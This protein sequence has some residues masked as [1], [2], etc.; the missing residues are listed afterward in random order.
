[1]LVRFRQTMLC[2][3]CAILCR[4]R[5]SACPATKKLRDECFL[6]Y[7]DEAACAKFIEAHNECL[8]KDGFNV[9]AV[10]WALPVKM[11]ARSC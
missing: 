4:P 2:V 3:S 9:R 6:K 10:V 7:G 1:M 8:R 11:P 5:Y